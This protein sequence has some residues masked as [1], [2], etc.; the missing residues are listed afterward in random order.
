MYDKAAKQFGIEVK[1]FKRSEKSFFTYKID[2]IDMAEK[3]LRILNNDGYPMH[4]N[5]CLI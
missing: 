3:D 4:F 5:I 2:N 1:T